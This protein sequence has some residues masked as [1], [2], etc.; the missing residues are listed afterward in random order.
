[1]GLG[2][3]HLGDGPQPVEQRPGAFAQFGKA[4]LDPA[5]VAKERFELTL[6][7]DVPIGLEGRD[8]RHI[9]KRAEAAPCEGACPLGLPDLG[10]DGGPHLTLGRSAAPQSAWRRAIRESTAAGIPPLLPAA[11]PRKPPVVPL[12]LLG[13]VFEFYLADAGGD[14]QADAA[15]DADRLQGDLL[16]AAAK[17]DIGAA[18]PPTVA[19]PCRRHSCR[20]GRPERCYPARTPATRFAL[21]W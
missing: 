1:M 10:L 6:D 20:R 21:P 8:P 11:G 13:R 12:G 7:G 19:G 2:V 16:A 14:V 3:Q 15:L 18:P 9:R 5:D 4:V 17:Q